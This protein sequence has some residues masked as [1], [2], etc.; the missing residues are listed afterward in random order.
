MRAATPAEAPALAG[1]HVAAFPPAEAWGP[2]A[3][4][5]M[6]EMPGAYGLWRPGAGFVLARAAG[7]E[8][9]IL[10]LAVAPAARRQGIGA[11]LMAGALAGAAARGAEAMFLEV[12]AGNAAALALYR[13]LGFAEVGRRR[14]YY[15]DGADALVLRRDLLPGSACPGA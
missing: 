3:I 7:G 8:A 13:G 15:A 14:R 6:L 9:E 5:L 12:A 4:A 11:A 1:L 10:T 2:D